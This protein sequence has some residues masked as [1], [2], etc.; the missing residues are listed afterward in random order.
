MKRWAKAAL[1]LAAVLVLVVLARRFGPAPLRAPA[2][3]EL[4]ATTTA[5]LDTLDLRAVRAS[6]ALAGYVADL[7]PDGAVVLADAAGYVRVRF[8]RPHQSEALRLRIGDRLLVRG[9]VVAEHGRPTLRPTDWAGTVREAPEAL[10]EAAEAIVPGQTYP[11]DPPPLPP[12]PPPGPP[13]RPDGAPAAG[14][15]HR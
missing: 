2:P 13:L 7:E 11:D 15:Q 5:A 9:A 10:L 8:R 12:M 6:A 4:G 3:L 14:R 1:A